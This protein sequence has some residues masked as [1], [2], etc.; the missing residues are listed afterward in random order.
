MLQFIQIKFLYFVAF[1]VLNKRN[2]TKLVA[3]VFVSE[4]FYSIPF[5]LVRVY[6]NIPEGFC[7]KTRTAFV[8]LPMR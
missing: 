2:K 7:A 6:C 8:R 5:T 3:C 4:C 1:L